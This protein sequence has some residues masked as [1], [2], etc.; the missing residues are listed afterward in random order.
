M[1]DVTIILG[2][3]EWRAIKRTIEVLL[4]TRLMNG[5]LINKQQFADE[6]E[7]NERTIQR[8]IDDIRHFLDVIALETGCRNYVVY[9]RQEKGF[10]LENI[11]KI[12]NSSSENE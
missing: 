11:Y 1:F 3:L 7:V 12:E 6:F 2:G 10:R 4:Y 8:D 5:E 9:D